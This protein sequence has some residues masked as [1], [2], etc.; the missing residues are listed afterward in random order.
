MNKK[1]AI[2]FNIGGS[3]ITSTA[4]NIEDLQILPKT[5]HFKAK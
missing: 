5:T 4:L 2:G 3:H 1:I